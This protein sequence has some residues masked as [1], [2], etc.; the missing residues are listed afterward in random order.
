MCRVSVLARP[1]AA[2]LC[3]GTIEAA[4]MTML[5]RGDG[6]AIEPP[7]TAAPLLPGSPSPAIRH[8]TT[9]AWARF[10]SRRRSAISICRSNLRRFP[11][12]SG[13]PLLQ[14]PE[15][16]SAVSKA[17][18]LVSGFVAVDFG[19]SPDPAPRCRT[20]A[21]ILI[22]RLPCHLRINP[23]GDLPEPSMRPRSMDRGGEE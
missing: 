7:S 15:P 6:I 13:R 9:T 10:S 5:Q 12:T 1:P 18:T 19:R 3:L 16:C 21:T 14:C 22:G 8:G 23:D 20:Q 11:F 17:R 4:P 2:P